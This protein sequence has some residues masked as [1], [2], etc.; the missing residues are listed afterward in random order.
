MGSAVSKAYQLARCF[1][2]EVMGDVGF[3]EIF[4]RISPAS[5]FAFAENGKCGFKAR[6]MRPLQRA[7]KAKTGGMCVHPAVFLMLVE[8]SGIEPLTSAM[9]LQRSPS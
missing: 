5:L 3:Q 9:P 1:V 7:P 2:S 4:N 6:R 8:V